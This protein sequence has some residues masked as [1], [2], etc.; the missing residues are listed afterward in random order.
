MTPAWRPNTTSLR[1]VLPRV[2]VALALLLFGVPQSQ[3]A[4]MVAQA[5]PS[6]LS[7]VEQCDG[8]LNAQR[9]VL[10]PV[11]SDDTLHDAAESDDAVL[12]LWPL[13]A[14]QMRPARYASLLPVTL[15]ILPPVRGPPAV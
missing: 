14:T 4:A 5:G 10:R 6:A 9:H 11:L 13:T 8:L 2:L 1:A 12:D 7:Q 3:V 15:R